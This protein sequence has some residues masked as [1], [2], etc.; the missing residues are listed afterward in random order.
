MRLL[1]SPAKQLRHASAD[2]LALTQPV[3]SHKADVLASLLAQYAPFELESLLHC[4]PR[5]AM[6]AFAAYQDFSQADPLCAVSSFWG[7]QFQHLS[8]QDFSREDF[9][10]AQEHLRI[11]SA[12]Y[13]VLRPLDAIKPHR[14]EFACSFRPQGKT[15]YQFWDSR[16]AQFLKGEDTLFLN[17]ASQEYAREVLPQLQ[18]SGNCR[19]VTCRFYQ[20]KRGKLTTL[21]TH[22]KMARGQMA[23]WIIKNR[24]NSLD[25]LLDFSWGGYAFA[26][27]YSNGD[28]LTFIQ[29][30]KG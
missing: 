14:L 18:H 7:I 30:D 29:I 15:L 24:L 22:A 27:L 2:A 13:G 28:T 25:E 23:R 19:V 10:F 12:L 17:L 6:D 26:P 21:A 8:P 16:P 4:N 3:F 20:T 9:L 5:L 11:L 1:I